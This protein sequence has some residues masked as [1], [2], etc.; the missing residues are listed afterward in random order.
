MCILESILQDHKKKHL[1]KQLTDN[2]SAEENGEGRFV[3][4]T[5]YADRGRRSALGAGEPVQG[6]TRAFRRAQRAAAVPAAARHRGPDACCVRAGPEEE[7]I[8]Y[9]E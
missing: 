3:V 9:N 7:C 5:G 6:A 8:M 1:R 4:A 2:R